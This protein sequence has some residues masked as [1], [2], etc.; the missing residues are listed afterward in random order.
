MSKKLPCWMHEIGYKIRGIIGWP[1]EQ[2]KSAKVCPKGCCG[3]GH[4]YCKA[5]R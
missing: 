3:H 2:L 1:V 5:V 4:I